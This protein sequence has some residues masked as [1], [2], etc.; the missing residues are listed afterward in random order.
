MP[1]TTVYGAT[2]PS[3]STP[4]NGKKIDDTWQLAI[5]NSH[6]GLFICT[7]NYI[8]QTEAAQLTCGGTRYGLVNACPHF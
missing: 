1:A 3:E 5:I 8:K 4:K 6:C 2:A 7:A